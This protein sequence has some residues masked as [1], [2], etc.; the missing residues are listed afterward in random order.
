MSWKEKSLRSAPKYFVEAIPGGEYF[1]TPKKL[2]VEDMRR[3]QEMQSNC[4][5]ADGSMIFSE[6]TTNMVKLTL[7]KG[8]FEHNLDNSNGVV[9]SWGEKVVDEILDDFDL[10]IEI[11]THIMEY[12]TPLAKKTPSGSA[13]SLSGCISEQLTNQEQDC[14]TE[15]IQQF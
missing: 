12:N 2:S 5:S 8:V 13:M 6:E 9:E 4:Q 11:F 7:L 10:A 1:I 14:Q 3:I 15:V